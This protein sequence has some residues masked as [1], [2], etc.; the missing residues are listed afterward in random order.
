MTGETPNASEPI[1]SEFVLAL[2][3]ACNAPWIVGPSKFGEHRVIPITGGTFTG[4]RIKGDV[5][6]GGADL[7]VVR[8]D[9]V[10]DLEA[11]YALRADDGAIITVR[12][13]G[14]AV[15]HTST[16]LGAAAQ[17]EAPDPGS[18][19]ARTMPEFDA[20]SDGP[21]AW[22]NKSLFVATLAVV[23]FAPLLVRLQVF[24]VL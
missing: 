23:S 3:V 18:M 12:N 14:I 16:D 2:E 24:R 15:Q 10:L 1:R 11:R 20:P 22:L 4:P 5:L 8:K 9:G 7:Q 19:Y 6:P 13:R 17:G 21:H